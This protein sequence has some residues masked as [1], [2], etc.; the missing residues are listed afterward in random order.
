MF[1]IYTPQ[2]LAYQT[3]TFLLKACFRGS[4]EQQ[5]VVLLHKNMHSR[6]WGDIGF[7][8]VVGTFTTLG[9]CHSCTEYT[10]KV[11]FGPLLPG[12]ENL[13]QKWVLLQAI[14][15]QHILP[16]CLKFKLGQH[17]VHNPVE[18]LLELAIFPINTT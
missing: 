9:A 11:R 18:I 17:L 3:G 2:R 4:V 14:R 1:C 15:N 8:H 10:T 6:S 16:S 5:L 7:Q 13:Y 12:L